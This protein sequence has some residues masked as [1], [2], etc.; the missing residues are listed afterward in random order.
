MIEF[1]ATGTQT[2][3]AS[4]YLLGCFLWATFFSLWYVE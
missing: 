1:L 3:T 2:L 4:G